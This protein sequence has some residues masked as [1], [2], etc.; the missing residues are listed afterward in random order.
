M[1]ARCGWLA[2]VVTGEVR[3]DVTL[4][5]DGERVADVLAGDATTP[6]GPVLDLSGCVVAPGLIDLHTHLAGMRSPAPTATS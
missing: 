4:V 5:F 3:P 1:A 2:D 6:D